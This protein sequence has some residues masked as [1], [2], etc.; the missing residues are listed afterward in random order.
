MS[1][2]AICLRPSPELLPTPEDVRLIE[3]IYTLRCDVCKAGHSEDNPSHVGCSVGM[4]SSAQYRARGKSL[5]H[6]MPVISIG[7]LVHVEINQSINWLKFRNTVQS[8]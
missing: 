6:L 5:R 2:E 4:E 1:A 7:N 8:H 3:L